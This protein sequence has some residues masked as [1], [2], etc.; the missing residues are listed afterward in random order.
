M[1]SKAEIRRTTGAALLL[2]P[3]QRAEKSAR[4]CEAIAASEA[5]RGARTVAI[6]APM[7][8]EPDVELL[9]AH[10]A[11][12]VFA[13][14]RVNGDRLDLFT[15]G[16]M[17]DLAPGALGV[18]EPAADPAR[19]TAPGELDLIL[20]PGAAFTR[21]GERLGRGGGFYDRLLATLTPR[22]CKIGVCFAAQLVPGLPVEPHDQHV[23][24]LATEDG[25]APA[26]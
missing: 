15:V 24:F 18:R 23:H 16:S 14:P 11:G 21:A 22:T 2:T 26:S 19:A 9:W 5:W 8:R 20:V 17:Y 3:D 6:F 13:Y 7:S 4:I 1:R 12:K 10:G 25:L